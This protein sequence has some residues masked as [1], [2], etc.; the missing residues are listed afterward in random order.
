MNFRKLVVQ[1]GAAAV[2]AVGLCGCLPSSSNPMEERQEPHYL[3]GK[4]RVNSLD[5]QGAIESFEKALEVNPRS[6]S[7]HFKLGCLFDEN[8]KDPAAAIYHYEK[9]LKLCPKPENAALV[10]GRIDSLKQDLAR[11]VMPLPVT[12]SLQRDFELLAEE[13]KRLKEDLARWQA[14][15]TGQTRVA[16]NVDGPILR[17]R[18]PDPPGGTSAPVP[19]PRTPGVGAAPGPGR[20]GPAAPP[21]AARPRT[22]TVKA[23][24]NPSAIAKQYGVK[25]DALMAANPRLDPKRLKVGQTLNIPSP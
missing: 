10:R 16:T 14:Y 4:A 13:N 19:G 11:A 18:R 2:L 9:Y 3:A 21:P 20:A 23:G 17:L 7:A 15:A 6:S 22:H 1:G 24:E 5:Y 25:L 12:S 8:V